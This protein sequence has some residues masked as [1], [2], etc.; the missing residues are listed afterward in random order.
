MQTF[1]VMKLKEDPLQDIYI[2]YQENSPIL[3]KSITPKKYS[4]IKHRS[5]IFKLNRMYKTSYIGKTISK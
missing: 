1:L 3:W 4:L 2:L 5:R